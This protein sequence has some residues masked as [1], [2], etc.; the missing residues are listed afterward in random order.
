[1]TLLLEIDHMYTKTTRKIKVTV[2]PTYLSDQ[3]DPESRHYV[4]AYTI[5][6]ENLGE[7]TVQLINR[8]WHITDATGAV[9]EVRGPGVV[10]EQPRLEQGDSYRYTSGTSLKTPSG[11]MVGTYEMETTSGERFHIDIP[12]FSLDSPDQVKRPN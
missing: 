10:G 7:E 1:M 6:I 4:W 2:I 3:S 12:A 11:I 9:Q 5:E 8:Y